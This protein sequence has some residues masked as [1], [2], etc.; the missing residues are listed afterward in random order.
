MNLHEAY[1]A[2]QLASANG[3]V[4]ASMAAINTSTLGYT[5]K[6]LMELNDFNETKTGFKYPKIRPLKP[7]K[8]ILSYKVNTVGNNPQEWR[9]KNADGTVILSVKTK[10]NTP[11]I[12]QVFELKEAAVSMDVY[13]NSG[14]NYSEFM[15]RDARI[16]DSG[17]EPFK[18]TID[19]RLA[20]LENA[21]S[22]ANQEEAI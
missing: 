19:E 11:E 10:N 5:A 7:G 20:A 6:N 17:F 9:W 18:P 21:V 4:T 12:N 13:F 16:S 1:L 3:S 8:Y 15:L 14:G 2:A 22:S